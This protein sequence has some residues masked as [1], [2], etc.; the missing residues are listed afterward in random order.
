MEGLTSK[1]TARDMKEHMENCQGCSQIYQSMAAALPAYRTSPDRDRRLIKKLKR[2]LRQNS[3]IAAAVTCI[4]FILLLFALYYE[5]PLAFD[6]NRM[7]VG[8]VPSVFIYD[9][10]KD[11]LSPRDLDSL[12]LEDMKD[13][14]EGKYEVY[15]LARIGYRGIKNTAYISQS[16]TINRDGRKVRITYFCFYKTL[17]NSLFCG[18]L[19][20]NGERGNSFCD[21]YENRFPE[22]GQR[23]RPMETEIYYLQDRALLGDKTKGLSDEAFDKLKEKGWLI[24]GGTA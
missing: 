17:W 12:G 14:H 9:E 1:E 23:Y 22:K 18:D 7:T 6:A 19:A 5:I 8:P 3:I 10:K 2:K 15:D 11:S 24:W 4:L 13:V 21:I 20:P 16:R